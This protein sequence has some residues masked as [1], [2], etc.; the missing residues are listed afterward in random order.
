M[1]DGRNFTVLVRVIVGGQM[2]TTTKIQRSRLLGW[3][4]SSDR[5]FSAGLDGRL[6]VCDLAH[7]LSR[8]W[9]MVRL[10]RRRLGRGAAECRVYRTLELRNGVPFF[11]SRCFG[12]GVIDVSA[13]EVDKLGCVR[14]LLASTLVLDE[15]NNI[16]FDFA[17]L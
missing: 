8:L 12:A 4:L 7:K 6:A 16:L 11:L 17:V 3:L 2:A 1:R 13:T 15:I 10:E 5:G 14:D 9:I